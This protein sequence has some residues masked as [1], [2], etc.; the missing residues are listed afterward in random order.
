MV[1]VKAYRWFDMPNG[2]GYFDIKRVPYHIQQIHNPLDWTDKLRL[3]RPKD[4]NAHGAEELASLSNLYRKRQRHSKVPTWHHWIY[5]SA[6]KQPME[7]NIDPWDQAFGE[8]LQHRD[9]N[10]LLGRANFH[11]I[12]CPGHFL[13]GA[14]GVTRPTLLHFTTE[15][16][17]QDKM[18]HRTPKRKSRVPTLNPVTVRLFELPLSDAVITGVFPSYFE[19]LRVITASD[20]SFWTSQRP[21]SEWG[22]LISQGRKMLKRLEKTHAWTY[23]RLAK[24]EE[25]WI[26]LWLMDDMAVLSIAHIVSGAIPAIPTALV[27]QW[28]PR[29][30]QRFKGAKQAVVRKDDDSSQLEQDPAGRDPVVQALRRFLDDMS[31]EDREGFMST[32]HGARLLTKIRTDLDTKEW[33]GRGEALDGVY[34]AMGEKMEKGS[35]GA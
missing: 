9:E 17:S 35:E 8:L 4:W 27:I 14:W 31:E 18:T 26:Q 3:S 24:V 34:D 28:W 19:Q 30:S 2:Q 16:P 23:G 33:S 11:Y 21:Y 20:S 5:A 12:T 7:G 6:Q 25:R 32:P 22:Q 13:C 1:M 10:E 15:T 29:I